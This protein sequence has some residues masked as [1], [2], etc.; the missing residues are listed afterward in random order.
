M[1]YPFLVCEVDC[2][3]KLK[4]AERQAMH[5][6]SIAAVSF[7]TSCELQVQSGIQSM[8]SREAKGVRWLVEELK[9]KGT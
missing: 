3:D 7:F 5:S 6:A 2:S 8:M 1:Y 4:E 9:N